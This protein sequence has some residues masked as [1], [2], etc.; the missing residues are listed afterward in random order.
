MDAFRLSFHSLRRRSRAA[1]PVRCPWKRRPRWTGFGGSGGFDWL[2]EKDGN[3]RDLGEGNCCERFSWVNH[4]STRWWFQTVF[5]FTQTLG[6][7]SNL[8]DMIQ[9]WKV[10]WV[11]CFSREIRFFELKELFFVNWDF[12]NFQ[13]SSGDGFIVFK[14]S[15]IQLKKKCTLQV[16][17]YNSSPF[18]LGFG[19]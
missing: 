16:Y 13:P 8:T 11:I 7:W 5:I 1:C 4:F 3:V 14:S 15:P 10:F 6:K 17:I 19:T 12:P 2:H 9:L 18:L